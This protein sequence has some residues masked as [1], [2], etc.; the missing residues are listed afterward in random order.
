[1][2]HMPHDADICVGDT[3]VTSGL[4]GIYP[5]GI[6]IGEV[7]EITIESG[8]LTKQATVEPYVNFSKLEEVFILTRTADSYQAGAA[9]AVDQGE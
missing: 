2:I 7:T 4:D 5:A 3:I 6:R 1:M 8:G 9:A